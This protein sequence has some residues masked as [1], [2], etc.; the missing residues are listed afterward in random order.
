MKKFFLFAAAVAT[1]LTVN[2]ATVKVLNE[3]AN[4]IDFQAL[5]V[6]DPSMT[7]HVVTSTD[8]YELPNGTKLVGFAKSDG[9]EA[10]NKWNVKENYNTMLP[11]PTWE[12]VD[13]LE[14]GTMFRA[15]S[16]TTIVLGEFTTTSDGQ[17]I[18]FYQPNGDSDRGVSISVFGEE[19]EGTN[20]TGSGVKIDGVR[21]GYAGFIALP[22]GVYDAGDVV[23]KLVSN[24]SNIFGVAITALPTSAVDNVKADAKTIKT[25]ENGQVVIIKNG[26]KYNALGTEIR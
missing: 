24:T 1:A 19:I 22:A 10:E 16:G 21:P 18:V 20:L 9:S 2:A 4:Y 13:S 12:G 25:I 8:P 14:V 7:S 26:V 5:S 23:I 3:V 15:A 11:T 17:V 6:A